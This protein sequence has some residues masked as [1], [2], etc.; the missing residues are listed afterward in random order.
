L[1]RDVR[2]RVLDSAT[3]YDY[4]CFMVCIINSQYD[5]GGYIA[6]VFAGRYSKPVFCINFGLPTGIV[7]ITGRAPENTTIDVGQVLRECFNGGGHKNAGSAG[8]EKGV[9]KEFI[10]SRIVKCVGNTQGELL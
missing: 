8:V 6:S 5:L 9:S 7:K 3:V 2:K 1:Y 10:I 4:E